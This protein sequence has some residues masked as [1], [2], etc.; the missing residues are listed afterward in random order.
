[1][2]PGCVRGRLVQ[3]RDLDSGLV[4]LGARVSE[5]NAVHAGQG[6]QTVC[7]LFLQ[8]DAIQVG[9]VHQFGSLV[10]K[11]RRYGRMRMSQPA[12]RDAAECVEVLPVFAVPQPDAFTTLESDRESVIG[13]HQVLGHFS[14]VPETEK[15]VCSRL[16]AKKQFYNRWPEKRKPGQGRVCVSSL[17]LTRPVAAWLTFVL[18]GQAMHMAGHAHQ[19][20]DGQQGIGAGCHQRN[21]LG[22]GNLV[23]TCLDDAENLFLVRPE[24]AAGRL[25]P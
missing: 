13:R 9:G 3:A 17:A 16:P 15:A 10:G 5:K 24:D 25:H 1:M 23:S 12:Y 7:Q 11:R 22:A 21:L 19:H 18:E 14:A 20:R 2:S 4:P 8:R 6:I